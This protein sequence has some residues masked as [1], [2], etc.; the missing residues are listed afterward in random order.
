MTKITATKPVTMKRNVANLSGVS[1]VIQYIPGK[2]WNPLPA[3][4]PTETF[5]D[6]MTDSPNRGCS[7]MA[8]EVRATVGL[9]IMW[10]LAVLIGV[11]F[12]G[13]LALTLA[14]V[15]LGVAVIAHTMQTSTAPQV[16]EPPHPLRYA[17]PGCGGDV[18]MGQAVCHACGHSLIGAQP[19]SR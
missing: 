19:P 12:F 4:K 15:F 1:G 16:T 18:Y 5:S 11:Y 14:I 3:A 17:C 13:E 8:R 2:A 7:S 9:A 6:S 10:I